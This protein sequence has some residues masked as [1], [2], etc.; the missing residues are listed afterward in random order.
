VDA[1][2]VNLKGLDV[3]LSEPVLVA[4]SH[5][6]CWFPT[7]ARLSNGNLVAQMSAH[8]DESTNQPRS[9]WAWSTDGGLTWDGKGYA[10]GSD[11]HVALLTSGDTLFLPYH[12]RILPH[13]DMAAPYAICRRGET[14]LQSLDEN[15]TVTGWPAPD[16]SNVET[17]GLSGFGFDG[18]SVRLKDGKYLATL[19]GT[20]KGQK[21][22]STVVAES[23]DAVHWT[24]RAVVA[25]SDTK[26]HG[27][28]GPCEPALCRLL[29]DFRLMCVF[30]MGAVDTPYGQSY[31]SDEG[32]TWTAAVAI[33]NA[34]SVQP[35]LAVMRDGTVV[36]SGGRPGVYLWIDTTGRGDAWQQV[37]IVPPEDIAPL[38]WADVAKRNLNVLKTSCYSEVVVLD[39]RHLLVIYDQIP[40]GWHS[41]PPE[42]TETNSVWVMRVTVTPQR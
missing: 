29:A 8:P 38:T 21:R 30:R 23:A 6:Y 2:T 4:R 26:L 27:R 36:L 24:V 20:F 40:C 32:R 12:L 5:G 16:E 33:P 7:M 13:G 28:E 9:H 42:S 1:R 41:I 3:T 37:E 22:Y 31:S 19:Y 39:E 25:G 11:V 14:Q 15:V 10:F 34:L 35:S 18:Q 17:P